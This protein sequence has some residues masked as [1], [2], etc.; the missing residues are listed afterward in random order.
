MGDRA[1]KPPRPVPGPTPHLTPGS[2][3]RPV[4]GPSS[5]PGP[6][7]RPTSGRTPT[8]AVPDDHE[9]PLLGRVLTTLLREDA[10]GLRTRARPLRRADGDWL[11][12]PLGPGAGH[13]LLPV[14]PDGFQ[15]DLVVRL[16]Y[17]EHQ[18]DGDPAL[19]PPA[20]LDT[21][22]AVLDRV[23]RITTPEDHDRYDAFAV[24]CRAE[25]AALRLHDRIRPGVVGRLARDHGD[26]PADHWRGLAGSLAYDTLA[27]FRG[28]PVHPT[29]RARIGLTA[30]QLTPYAPEFHPAFVLRWV[31]LPRAAVTGDPARLPAWW[32]TPGALGLPALD[33]TH[34]ALPV[35][36]LTVGRALPA[37]LRAAGLAD[38]A[39]LADRAFIDVRPT[40]ST[41]TVATLRDPATHLKLPLPTATLG[42]LNRRTIKPGTL[43]DG[44]VAQRLLETVTAREPVLARTLLLADE[45]T[46][47]HADHEFLATLI[48][49][50]PAGLDHCQVVPV[51]ALLAATPQGTLVADALADRFYGGDLTAFLDAYLTALFAVHTTLFAYGVALEAHQQNTSLVLDETGLRLL[52]KDHDGPRVHPGRLAAALGGD[53]ARAAELCGGF[54]DRRILVDGDG[55]L[56]D[57]F[58]TITVHLCAAAPL[59]EL[60]AR[61]RVGRAPLLNLLRRRLGEAVDQLDGRP[62]APGAALR[63]RVLD[64]GRLPV[65]AMVTAGSLY[66]KERS[67]AADI[68]KHYTSGPNYLRAAAR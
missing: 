2:V 61:G 38:D 24:E 35:H 25:L 10:Y 59:F 56:T 18:P 58:T 47:L 45:T 60:A 1:V 6:A 63:A 65:K 17:A 68:N 39:H 67:G 53:P 55:A 19:T 33:G 23:R 4:S 37:V 42:A 32:P 21:L 13:L 43:T 3:P 20:T 28:H 8:R 34:L 29:G 50:Y 27:A 36:P 26:R 51:A 62:E 16:P 52:V 54:D 30:D 7:P 14:G 31:A 49:R 15:G 11:R 64:A 40:L 46:C 41:R 5:L 9:P 57:V 48:R 66:P 12:V 44:A 22:D